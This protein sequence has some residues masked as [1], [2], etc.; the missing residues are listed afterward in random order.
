MEHQTSLKNAIL[1]NKLGE[2][3]ENRNVQDV[4]PYGDL[5]I[6]DILFSHKM[7]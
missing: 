5:G 7:L 3:T 6:K 4:E 2:G 1:E